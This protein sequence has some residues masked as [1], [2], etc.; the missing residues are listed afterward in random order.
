MAGTW[1]VG[2]W[3]LSG[4]GRWNPFGQ[5]HSDRAVQAAADAAAAPLPV[6]AT[7]VA[8]TAP[9]EAD[10]LAK[11]Q[12]VLAALE[13][14]TAQRRV[15]AAHWAFGGVAARGFIGGMAE[16]A[17]QQAIAE[18][19]ADA[20]EKR[21]AAINDALKTLT[22]EFN[23]RE[24]A[25]QNTYANALAAQTI[26]AQNRATAV[27]AAGNLPSGFMGGAGNFFRNVFSRRFWTGGG[28]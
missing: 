28:S 22:D 15:Q 8:G 2:S 10:A 17:S 25:K 21:T 11:A 16:D 13:Q 7:P 3:N 26:E 9:T 4:R 12:P 23:T 20:A 27:T 24:Q 18:V 1:D 19:D 14:L 5:S 6:I